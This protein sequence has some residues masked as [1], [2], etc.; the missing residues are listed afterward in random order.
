VK[1]LPTPNNQIASNQIN[2]E[3]AWKKRFKSFREV[4]KLMVSN[5]VFKGQPLSTILDEFIKTAYQEGRLDGM[6][7][8][9]QSS[10]EPS[11]DMVWTIDHLPEVVRPPRVR[12]NSSFVKEVLALN[13]TFG[14]YAYVSHKGWLKSFGEKAETMSKGSL[15]NGP[16][17]TLKNHGFI[18]RAITVSDETERNGIADDDGVELDA[19]S[20][21]YS[22]TLA[23]KTE[24]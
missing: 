6:G 16:R 19:D 7:Q 21:I 3:Q 23:E 10:D 9:I 4:G 18:C 12:G 22:I 15:N 17:Y 20:V 24:L 1:E 2:K 14:D 8:Q 5:T 13:M 11:E